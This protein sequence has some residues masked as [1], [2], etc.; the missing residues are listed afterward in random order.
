M[1]AGKLQCNTIHEYL[2]LYDI[3]LPVFY[4]I[5]LLLQ[6]PFHKNSKYLPTL[7]WSQNTLVEYA[8]SSS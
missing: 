5:H 1:H 7:D 3:F 6:H 8:L 4:S 2:P